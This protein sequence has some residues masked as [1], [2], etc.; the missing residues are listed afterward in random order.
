[1]LTAFAAFFTDFF[2]GFL[3]GFFLT[4][5]FLAAAFFAGAFFVAVF[6]VAVFFAAAFFT[7]AFFVGAFFA[8]AFLVDVFLAADAN[9][10]SKQ[11]SRTGI[12]CH[13]NGFWRAYNHRLY[14]KQGAKTRRSKENALHGRFQGENRSYL[15]ANWPLACSSP[16]GSRKA[17]SLKSADSRQ[18]FPEK[19]SQFGTLTLLGEALVSKF[20]I[21]FAETGLTQL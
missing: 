14:W 19:W 11:N 12:G 17:K 21:F 20:R 13:V 9:L 2:A 10:L 3:A 18:E 6:F 15:L 1:M 8:G 4:A 5:V 7:G 16:V